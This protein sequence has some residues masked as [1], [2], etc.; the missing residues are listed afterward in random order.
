MCICIQRSVNICILMLFGCIRRINGKEA[1]VV[2]HKKKTIFR[3]KYAQIDDRNE[4]NGPP[5]KNLHL[6]I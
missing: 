6:H 5:I 3:K 4:K 2:I 1:L